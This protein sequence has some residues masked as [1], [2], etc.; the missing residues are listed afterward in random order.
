MHGMATFVTMGQWKVSLLAGAVRHVPCC[1]CLSSFSYVP[2][3]MVQCLKVLFNAA[4]CFSCSQQ[5]ANSRTRRVAA[6][7]P[8]RASP[9][10]IQYERYDV[11]GE[12]VG[13]SGGC[14]VE[15]L[16]ICRRVVRPPHLPSKNER[17]LPSG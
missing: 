15:H 16:A 5:A 2:D 11:G 14:P 9:E 10:E 7:P 6:A 1:P 17:V 8:A 12:V 13:G 3:A 4:H